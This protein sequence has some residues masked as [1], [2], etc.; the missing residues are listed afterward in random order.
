MH[1]TEASKRETKQIKEKRDPLTRSQPSTK[2]LG[3]AAFVLTLLEKKECGT[4]PTEL[5]SSAHPVSVPHTLCRVTVHLRPWTTSRSWNRDSLGS[6]SFR[7]IHSSK[8]LSLQ[9]VPLP[10]ASAVTHNDAVTS[11]LLWNQQHQFRGPLGKRA[12][13]AEVTPGFL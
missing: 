4:S 6:L 3:S 1:V 7:N 10:S 5:C 12:P 13:A 9:K 11:C 8:G 2:H